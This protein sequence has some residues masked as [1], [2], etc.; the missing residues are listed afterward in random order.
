[1]MTVQKIDRTYLAIGMMSGTSVDGIDV[2]LIETNGRDHVKP[3]SLAFY[4]YQ[5]DEQASIRS[6]FGLE[7]D[8]DGRVAAASQLVTTR[9]IAA[10]QDFLVSHGLTADDVDVIGFH[11][12]TVFHAPDRGFTWQIGD[13]Q[14]VADATAIHVVCNMRAADVKAGGQGAPLVP[15]YHRALASTLEK[16]V[17]ILNLGGVGNVTYIGPQD[18]DL[19]A[20]DTG[21]GN[22]LIDRWV[23]QEAG[24]PYDGGGKLASEGNVDQASIDRWLKHPYFAAKPPKSLDVLD[25]WQDELQAIQDKNGILR[26]ARPHWRPIR[27]RQRRLRRAISRRHRTVGMCVVVVATIKPLCRDW[28][29]S[30][31][32]RYKRLK[33]LIFA[34]IQSRPKPLP[35]SPSGPVC[36]CR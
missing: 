8:E 21:P 6:C 18:T 16:P 17:A 3:L 23:R 1:M 2:A 20:F 25:L 15:L 30:C 28:P 22:A 12:Q 35:I 19:L 31:R 5:E 34:V 14:A 24:L 4:A 11:G 29:R 26:T 13:G 10:V 33:I 7:R 32:V 9:H 27:C 36:S